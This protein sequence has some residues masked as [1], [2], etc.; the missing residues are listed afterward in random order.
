MVPYHSACT[1]GI[2]SENIASFTNH[3]NLAKFPSQDDRTYQNILRRVVEITKQEIKDRRAR[4]VGQ[5]GLLSK[6]GHHMR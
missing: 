6:P 3:S 1:Y 2:P 5:R 4:K